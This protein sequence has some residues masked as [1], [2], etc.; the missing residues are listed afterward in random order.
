LTEFERVTQFLPAYD[1]RDPD[2]RKD[3]G[4]HGVDL[5][6]Y[7]K[8]SLGIVQFRLFTGWLLPETVGATKGDW[9]Q[10]EYH[11]YSQ[12]I[13]NQISARMYPMP[14]DLGY[15]WTSPRYRDQTGRNDCYLLDGQTCYYDGSTLNSWEPFE[16]LLREGSDGV[17]KYLE[18]YYKELA[19]YK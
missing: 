1:K 19:G 2:P 9:P 12:N 5:L 3:Y 6:M 17:F 8:G 14:A 4:V 15:H 16:V 10:V 13:N 7:V 18:D 11:D